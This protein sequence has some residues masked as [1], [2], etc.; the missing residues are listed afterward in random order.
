MMRLTSDSQLIGLQDYNRS[1]DRRANTMEHDRSNHSANISS[2][3][4]DSVPASLDDVVIT[5]ELARRPT[6]S[7][8]YAGEARAL[9]ALAGVMA[10][11]PQTILQKLVEAAVG[12]CRADSAGISGLEPGAAAGVFRWYAIAG[13]FAS[14]VGGGMPRESSPCGVVLDRD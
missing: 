8:A 5:A 7:P 4:M 13:Q 12:L 14:N 6:R 1:P 11:Q 2:E 10:A 3:S 9:P